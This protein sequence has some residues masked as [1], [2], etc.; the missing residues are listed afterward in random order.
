MRRQINLYQ[1]EFRPRQTPLPTASLLAGAG[2]FAAGLLLA[3]AW[4]AWQLRQHRLDA[5]AIEARATDI[6]Q[7]VLRAG[8]QARKLTPGLLA[9]ARQLEG[10][11]RNLRLLQQAIDSGALGGVSGYSSRFRALSR[12]VAQGAWLTHIDI[13]GARGDMDLSGYTLHGD[14]PARLMSALRQQ[15]QFAGLSYAVLELGPPDTE[16][17]AREPGTPASAPDAQKPPAAPAYLRFALR[18]SLPPG[19]P[20][21]PQPS[22]PPP[23]PRPGG[24]S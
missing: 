13:R 6:E 23:A 4:G 2:L 18:A 24:A 12:G 21:P 15:P 10:Q 19:A 5:D 14:G 3:Q 1:A 8:G 7:Q 17:G 11:T 9:E 22:T 16:D 20:P